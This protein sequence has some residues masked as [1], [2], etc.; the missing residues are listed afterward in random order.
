MSRQLDE[1]SSP[2]ADSAALRYG[3]PAQH[4]K[5]TNVTAAA[6]Q[7]DRRIDPY[8]SELLAHC[9]RMLGSVHDAEDLV[10]DTYLRAWG[11]DDR[12]RQPPACLRRRHAA[13]VRAAA[14]GLDPA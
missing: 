12:P 9:Y 4:G 2:T 3:A 6:E 10:Q 14:R 5:G 7:F 13:P 11:R 1:L 8:R